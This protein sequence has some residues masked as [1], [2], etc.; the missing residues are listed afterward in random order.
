MPFINSYPADAD[1]IDVY[2]AYPEVYEPWMKVQDAVMRGPSPLT[3]RER[4]IIAAYTSGLN[5]CRYCHGG[6]VFMAEALGVEEGLV[7][8]LLEDID[9]SD[10]AAAMKPILHY[11]RKLTLEPAKMT[12]AD[13][14]AVFTAGWDGK[15]LHDA[16]AVCAMFNFMNRL[17]D[18]LGIQ[19]A[20]TRSPDRAGEEG[21]RALDYSGLVRQAQ[22][23]RGARIG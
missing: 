14:D 15:A 17:V 1:P 2:T 7:A 13:A 23:V 5:A 16:I 4:E 20:Q 3:A 19:P 6:H 12:Q 18:G 21:I 9:A 22:K 11:V 10:A 8:S